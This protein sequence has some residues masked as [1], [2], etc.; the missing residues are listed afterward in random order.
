MLLLAAMDGISV[1]HLYLL[2]VEEDLERARV[3]IADSD[4]ASFLPSKRNGSICSASYPSFCFKLHFDCF[5][6]GYN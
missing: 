5:F 4:V 3:A 6:M 1:L 2:Q